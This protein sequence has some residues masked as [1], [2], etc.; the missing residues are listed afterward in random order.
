M[1]IILSD[2]MA[3]RGMDQQELSR[4]SGVP[5]PMISNIVTGR[6][7]T[8]RCDTLYS[9]AR[10]LRCAMEDLIDDADNPSHDRAG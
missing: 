7:P 1:R 8:P 2:M 9:L 6:T 5:Q 10:A 4:R 3:R